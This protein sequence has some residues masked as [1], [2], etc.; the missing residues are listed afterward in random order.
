MI[1]SSEKFVE[2]KIEFL[3]FCSLMYQRKWYT[4][5]LHNYSQWQNS[6]WKCDCLC[7]HTSIPSTDRQ[8]SRFLVIPKTLH[9]NGIW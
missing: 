2:L 5:L 7:S 3:G 1:E 9:A 8:I 4:S 6:V